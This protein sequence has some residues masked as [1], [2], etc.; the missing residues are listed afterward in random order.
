[1]AEYMFQNVAY[2]ATVY[3]TGHSSIKHNVEYDNLVCAFEVVSL[4]EVA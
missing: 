4:R 1:M 3:R 2:R